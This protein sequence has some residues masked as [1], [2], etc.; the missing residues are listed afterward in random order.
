VRIARVLIGS[1]VVADALFTANLTVAGRMKVNGHLSARGVKSVTARADRVYAKSL[2]SPSGTIFV[3]GD[4]AIVNSAEAPKHKHHKHHQAH[5]HKHKH[6][7]TAQG[8]TAASFLAE[9]LVI[10]GIKQWKLVRHESFDD[11]HAGEGWSFAEISSCTG[12]DHF[13][14]GHCKLGDGE[15]SKRFDQLPAHSQVRVTARYHMIDNWQGETAFLKLGEHYVWSD[16]SRPVSDPSQGLEMC[17]SKD[18]AERRMS[19]P[20]D[21]TLPHSASFLEM[22]FGS[23]ALSV[24][25]GKEDACNRSFGVDDVMVYVR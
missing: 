4:L 6:N 11:E 14:G 9:D 2:R 23:K 25:R 1:V 21:V 20:V 15:T 18:F 7:S 5:K 10:G 12:V 16:H 19:I 8:V 13:L 17:G 24:N 22:T 3:D